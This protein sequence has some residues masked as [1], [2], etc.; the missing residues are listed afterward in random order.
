MDPE[1]HST[2]ISELETKLANIKRNHAEFWPSEGRQIGVA[3]VPLLSFLVKFYVRKATWEPGSHTF[4]VEGIEFLAENGGLLKRIFCDDEEVEAKL[5][6][7]LEQSPLKISVSQGIAQLRAT[8]EW[9]RNVAKFDFEHADVYDIDHIKEHILKE[10]RAHLSAVSPFRTIPK[11]IASHL[12]AVP[13]TEDYFKGIILTLLFDTHLIDLYTTTITVEC[14]LARLHG[15]HR[16]QSCSHWRS[17]VHLLAEAQGLCD[18]LSKKW[19]DMLPE[20][21]AKRTDFLVNSSGTPEPPV[22]PAAALLIGIPFTLGCVLADTAFPS[23][24]DEFTD[25]WVKGSQQRY[26]RRLKEHFG[27]IESIFLKFL[28]ASVSACHLSK[29]IILPTP[30]AP[31]VVRFSPFDDGPR[32]YACRVL[33]RELES[34]TGKLSLNPTLTLSGS[35]NVIHPRSD[36]NTKLTLEYNHFD[37][38]I[39]E[40]YRQG[41]SEIDG[42]EDLV[43]VARVGP[44]LWEPNQSLVLEFDDFCMHDQDLPVAPPALSIDDAAPVPVPDASPPITAASGSYSSPVDIGPMVWDKDISG[45]VRGL[46][47]RMERACTIDAD[48]VRTLYA[49]QLPK[50][51]RFVTAFFS[52]N[53]AAIQFV[54]AWAAAPPAGYEKVSVSFSPGS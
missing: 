38:V 52:S 25:E 24:K 42:T 37:K 13:M 51:N 40:V 18:M 48:A 7:A 4:A 14:H 31:R 12:E 6:A 34:E 26:E 43:L 27:D 23:L 5:L 20:I 41:I 30:P 47:A 46:I 28:D 36:R 10:G 17:A 45:Q 35:A 3:L 8:M 21:R 39:V 1:V 11:T 49:K 19:R 50:N 33:C 22:N 15:G 32:F 44:R 29:Q 9:Q 54:N 2:E 53:I 16:L